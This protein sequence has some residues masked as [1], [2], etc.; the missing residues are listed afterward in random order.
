MSGPV[1]RK[2][3]RHKQLLRLAVASLREPKGFLRDRFHPPRFSDFLQNIVCRRRKITVLGVLVI[4]TVTEPARLWSP[5]NSI[6]TEIRMS[7]SL[8][9]VTRGNTQGRPGLPG[10][11]KEWECNPH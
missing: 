2:L 1:T 5:T 11:H 8:A 9:E 7:I 6:G 10:S 4:G 3:S